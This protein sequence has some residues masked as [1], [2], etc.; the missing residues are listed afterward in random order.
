MEAG[1]VVKAGTNVEVGT[2]AVESGTAEAGTINVRASRVG[3]LQKAEIAMKFRVAREA[4]VTR[5]SES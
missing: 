4:K 2:I 5:R 3:V 1:A